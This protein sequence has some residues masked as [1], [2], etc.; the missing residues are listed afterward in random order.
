[1]QEVSHLS[2]QKRRLV[3]YI[4]SRRKTLSRAAKNELRAANELLGELLNVPF[5]S[6]LYKPPSLMT[7]AM[8]PR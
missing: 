3:M 6:S 1:M 5:H 8:T 2:A 4:H 7:F